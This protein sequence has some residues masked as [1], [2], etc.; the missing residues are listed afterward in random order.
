M[1]VFLSTVQ[2]WETK[3][4]FVGEMVILGC[5][6]SVWLK[7]TVCLLSLTG[8]KAASWEPRSYQSNC[9]GCGV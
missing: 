6:A 9:R 5:A 1:I 8:A 2:L 4:S 7:Y 3:R